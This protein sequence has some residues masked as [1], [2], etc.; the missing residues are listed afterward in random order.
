M[1]GVLEIGVQPVTVL[2][3]EELEY[4]GDNALYGICNTMLPK[5]IK[6]IGANFTL[7]PSVAFWN[8]S[9]VKKQKPDGFYSWEY[10]YNI[11]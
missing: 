8:A 2:L 4:I 5:K 11:A 10:C 3:N 6:Y 9:D 1:G 7:L